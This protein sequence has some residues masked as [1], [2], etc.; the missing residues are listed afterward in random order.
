[1]FVIGL[2]YVLTQSDVKPISTD[3]DINQQVQSKEPYFKPIINIAEIVKKQKNTIDKI[4]GDP[5]SCEQIK[6]GSKCIYKNGKFEIV[7]INGLSDWITVNDL[8]DTPYQ[9]DSIRFFGLEP[10]RPSFSN[11]HVIRWENAYGLLSI[12]FFPGENNGLSYA[13]IKA[14]T[15]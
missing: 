14:T 13:Y 15:P 7:Y 9:P 1:M 12:Q 11:E 8:T 4:L 10:S 5:D 2:L 3:Q 6:Y